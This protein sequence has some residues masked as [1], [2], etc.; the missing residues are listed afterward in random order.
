MKESTLNAVVAG[1]A[2][3]SASLLRALDDSRHG[4]AH[5]WETKFLKEHLF[6]MQL[7]WQSGCFGLA[8]ML[9]GLVTLGRRISLVQSGM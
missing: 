3:N 8:V 6:R 9:R 5:Q 7:A 2:H 4:Q 1:R